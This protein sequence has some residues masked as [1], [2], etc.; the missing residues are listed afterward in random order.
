MKQS[1]D[2][3]GLKHLS[4]T[5]KVNA[6]EAF[7]FNAFF[8]LDTERNHSMSLVKIPRSAIMAY[9]DECGLIGQDSYDFLFVIRKLDDAH[10]EALAKNR[11][12][13]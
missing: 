4:E 11:K 9:A 12:N 7:Y 1:G 5:L 13:A 3:E 10:L 8:E 2:V 6:G